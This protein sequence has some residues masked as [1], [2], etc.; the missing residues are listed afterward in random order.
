MSTLI[1]LAQEAD[2]IIAESPSS[3]SFYYEILSK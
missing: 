3:K 1:I 2:F